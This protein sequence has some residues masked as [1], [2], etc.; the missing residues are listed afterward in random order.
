[1]GLRSGRTIGG[2]LRRALSNPAIAWNYMRRWSRLAKF[3]GVTGRDIRRYRAKLVADT[4]FNAHLKANRAE[5]RGGFGRVAELYVLARALKPDVVVETGVASGVS[6]AHWLRALARNDKGK[7]YSIDLPNLN[8]GVALPPGKDPGWIVP[9]NL[10]DR[11]DLRLGDSRVLLPELLASL[12]YV[13]IF[14]HDSDHAKEAMMFEFEAAFP[15]VR[16][17]GL[18]LSDDTNYNDAWDQFNTA[19]GLPGWR[20][21]HMGVARKP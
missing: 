12:S 6:S 8:D 21:V 17:G 18:I 13:D 1:V 11:W 9:D 2:D 3:A 19:H 16:A 15:K 14:F 10:R 5:A 4:P 7:L 20:V